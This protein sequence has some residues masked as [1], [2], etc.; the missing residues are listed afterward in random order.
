[1]TTVRRTGRVKSYSVLGNYGFVESLSGGGAFISHRE[2]SA[3]GLDSLRRGD[4]ITYELK[5]DLHGK[6]PRAVHL[7]VLEAGR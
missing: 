4:L 5:P 2:V 7:K 1:M 3:A 6:L